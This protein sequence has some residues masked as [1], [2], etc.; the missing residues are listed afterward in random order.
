MS[1]TVKEYLWSSFVTF[2]TAFLAS[3]IP[4]V[5]IGQPISEALLLSI[6]ATALRAGVRALLNLAATQG[7]TTSSDPTKAGV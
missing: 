6:G 1:S 5:N 3:A 4:L 7:T 2:I